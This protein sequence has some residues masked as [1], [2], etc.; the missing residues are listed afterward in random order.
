MKVW[1]DPV[2]SPP[3]PTFKAPWKEEGGGG[4]G[5]GVSIGITPLSEIRIKLFRKLSFSLAK[6]H[7]KRLQR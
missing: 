7:L 1:P 5:G 2:A 3:K 6:D 4:G